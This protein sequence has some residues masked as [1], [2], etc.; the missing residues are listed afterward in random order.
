ML[1][2]KAMAVLTVCRDARDPAAAEAALRE[3]AEIALAAGRSGVVRDLLDANEEF[4]SAARMEY[5]S[6]SAADVR[7]VESL[8]EAARAAWRAAN[9]TGARHPKEKDKRLLQ[10]MNGGL[11]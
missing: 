2:G 4:L 11:T 10:V 3:H 5:E 8:R 7:T 9:L 6:V 1:S